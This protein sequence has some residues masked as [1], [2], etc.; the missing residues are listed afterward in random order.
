MFGDSPLL[1]LVLKLLT[2]SCVIFDI[3]VS[4]TTFYCR[5]CVAKSY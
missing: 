4:T 5:K 3:L 1:L 2:I